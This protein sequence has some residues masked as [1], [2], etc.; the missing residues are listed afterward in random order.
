MALNPDTPIS[1]ILA[2]LLAHAPLLALLPSDNAGNKAIYQAKNVATPA[3]WP[4]VIIVPPTEVA[5]SI[6]I[7]RFPQTQTGDFLIMAEMISDQLPNDKALDEV[8]TPI[9]MALQNAL[10]GVSTPGAPTGGFAHSCILT[11][12]YSPAPLDQTDTVQT[13][14][15]GIRVRVMAT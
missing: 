8:L 15:K 13:G 11:G 10:L 14:Q 7:E 2:R 9:Q 12:F 3:P 1:W 6:W 4:H 5:L